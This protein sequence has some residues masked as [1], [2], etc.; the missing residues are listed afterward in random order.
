MGR[1][2]NPRRK[3]L[4]YHFFNSDNDRLN[5]IDSL[6]KPVRDWANLFI[7]KGK[8]RN[9]ITKSDDYLSTHLIDLPII[10]DEEWLLNHN[11]K[12]E[13]AN[14]HLKNL[15]IILNDIEE[16]KSLPL[17]NMY[18]IEIYEQVAKLA[19]FSYKL[20]IE[21][22]DYAKGSSSIKA[23]LNNEKE[24]KVLRN[25]FENVYSKTRI[26]NKSENYILDQDH[27]RHTANQ[28]IN[29]DWQFIGELKLFEKLNLT[30]K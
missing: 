13:I 26:I 28:S 23:L 10:N 30:Y 16:L 27:H 17:G 12:I 9:S 21:I 24:F 3:L 25:E 2:E 1:S 14:N 20:M 29:M 22:S 15:E 19:H 11:E 18:A 6:D 8:H 5:F 4:I 7:K